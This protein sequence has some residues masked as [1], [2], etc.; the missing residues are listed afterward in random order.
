MQTDFNN[1]FT[2]VVSGELQ[3]MTEYNFPPLLKPVTT[4]P[5]E[6]WLQIYTS[7]TAVR[8][9]CGAKYIIKTVNIYERYLQV[10]IRTCMQIT[11][12]LL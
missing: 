2:V 5:C 7:A 9:T 1:S 3:G 12:C 8:Y 6:I 11:V 4:L 10:V